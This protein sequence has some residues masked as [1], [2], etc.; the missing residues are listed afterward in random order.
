MSRAKRRAQG[1]PVERDALDAARAR[2][3]ERL[4]LAAVEDHREEPAP[5]RRGLGTELLEV[6]Q[7]ALDL[8]NPPSVRPPRAPDA[9][10]APAARIT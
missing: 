5:L 9:D 2:R 4:D 10:R 6:R 8:E 3:D 7:L 1:E